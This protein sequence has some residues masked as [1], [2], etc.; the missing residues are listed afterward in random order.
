MNRSIRNVLVTIFNVW[1]LQVQCL[2]CSMNYIMMSVLGMEV[3]YLSLFLIYR[4]NYH[5]SKKEMCI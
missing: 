5:K 1:I 4:N 3:L 2:S